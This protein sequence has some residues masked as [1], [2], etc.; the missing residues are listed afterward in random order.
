MIRCNLVSGYSG[1]FGEITASKMVMI[2]F[3]P[4]DGMHISV[5]NLCLTVND[6]GSISFCVETQT[7]DVFLS[8]I[9]D[10]CDVVSDCESL[11]DVE[12]VLILRGWE[13]LDTFQNEDEKGEES[14]DRGI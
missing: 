2:P 12:L 10:Y 3:L 13:I 7:L 14:N 4:K 1:K 6:N 9:E 8:D 5:D 11:S